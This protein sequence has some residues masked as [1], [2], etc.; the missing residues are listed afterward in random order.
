MLL[1]IS[2]QILLDYEKLKFVKKKKQK[3]KEQRKEN[4][5]EGSGKRGSL[6]AFHEDKSFGT[7]VY[8]GTLFLAFIWNGIHLQL[9][10][11][12]FLLTF[13]LFCSKPHYKPN[14]SP[15]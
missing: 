13:N 12:C 4:N 8:C 10:I 1:I 5:G 14:K 15:Y 9:A 2:A 11:C 7:L 6:D 3:Q